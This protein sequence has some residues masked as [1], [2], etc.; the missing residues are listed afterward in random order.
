ML[1]KKDARLESLYTQTIG[2][3]RSFKA[4]EIFS[5]NIVAELEVT[6][7]AL[8]FFCETENQYLTASGRESAEMSVQHAHELADLRKRLDDAH[9]MELQELNSKLLE[10]AHL[11]EEALKREVRLLD[12]EA[13]LQEANRN[14]SDS[15]KKFL[16]DLREKDGELDKMLVLIAEKDKAIQLL[17]QQKE[18]ELKL[19]QQ[20]NEAELKFIASEH[21]L[22]LKSKDAE[23][24]RELE[25]LSKAKLVEVHTHTHA[26]THTRTH[27]HTHAHTH[28]HPRTRTY[29][30]TH[31]RTHV[32][33][34]VQTH[35]HIYTYSL[36][37]TSCAHTH[38]NRTIE[39]I[40]EKKMI[41]KKCPISNLAN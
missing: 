23:L 27:T 36:G 10:E 29:A 35:T 17:L 5:R 4:A 16:G 6:R 41:S 1:I 37:C 12:E 19:L 31:I 25:A 32:Q 40:R 30:H 38:L 7:T 39:T 22:A 11:K 26:H 18:T 8:M 20:T 13:Q 24:L 34:H 15:V 33:K 9:A 21:L 3:E 2:L 14:T 28:T